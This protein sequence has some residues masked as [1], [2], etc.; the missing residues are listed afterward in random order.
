MDSGFLH[1]VL[2]L[3]W[4]TLGTEVVAA[5]QHTVPRDAEPQPLEAG[6]P[7][8]LGNLATLLSL[9]P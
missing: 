2:E 1:P 3:H 7:H 4:G 6:G 8:P 9:G 5:F